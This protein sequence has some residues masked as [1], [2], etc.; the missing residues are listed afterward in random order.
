MS[1]N[2]NDF[3]SAL[4]QGG[5]RP[6]LFR[7]RLGFPAG[8]GIVGLPKYEFL[9]RASSIPGVSDGV[10][11]V[12]F[13][14]R[15]FKVP[16]DKEFEDWSVTVYNDNDFAVHN[17]FIRWKNAISGF[18]TGEAASVSPADL[19]ADIQV[20][21]L[22]RQNDVVKRFTLMDAWPNDVAAIDL[23]FDANPD[24]EE[25]EVTFSYQYWLAAD[26]TTDGVG[27]FSA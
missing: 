3:K 2:I 10:V 15:T 5:A 6:N 7:V 4:S 26:G 25:F 20:E 18:Q 8:L 11:E 16:G 27:G 22:N 13:R 19:F 14:G 1:L 23:S 12:P 9:V 21:Q 24:I 17:D